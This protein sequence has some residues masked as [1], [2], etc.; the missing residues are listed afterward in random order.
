M[1]FSNEFVVPAPIAEAW[2]LLNDVPRIAPCLPGATVTPR[3]DGSYDGTVAVKV[4]PIKVSYQGTA[5]FR[6]QDAD[7]YR[8]VLDARG[9]ESSGRGSASAVV[10][11]A[12]EPEGTGKTRVLVRTE[13]QVTGK[14]AQFGR[15]AMAD[16][17]ARL[18]GTFADGLAELLGAG[19]AAAS[20]GPASRPAP[21]VA[22]AA[23]AELD[24]LA[25]VMPMLRRA[26]PVVA[27]FAAGV[28]VSRL[29]GRGRRSR[30][31]PP[32]A[33]PL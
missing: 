13:L 30:G 20:P 22:P 6:E 19:A 27:A 32:R 8:M 11:A 25:L 18:I 28:L 23:G 5:R 21:R 17:G 26:V 9:S 3:D 4:G 16:V 29:V 31:R 24:G 33:V 7:A 10:T 12:L 1:E 15:S 2:A 14:V